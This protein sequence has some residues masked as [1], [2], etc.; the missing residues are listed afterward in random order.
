MGHCQ[1]SQR[2]DKDF[3][4]FQEAIL[5]YFFINKGQTS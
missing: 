3:Q 2:T 5:M 1:A 4:V